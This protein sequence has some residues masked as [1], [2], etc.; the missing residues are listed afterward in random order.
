M[1]ILITILEVGSNVVM[2]GSGSVN[3]SS[4]GSPANTTANGRINP[5]GPF[6]QVGPTVGTPTWEYSIGVTGPTS[7]GSGGFSFGNSGSG[8]IFGVI[9]G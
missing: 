3:T 9:N 1:S 4:L 6:W 5:S 2:S 7:L 8:S